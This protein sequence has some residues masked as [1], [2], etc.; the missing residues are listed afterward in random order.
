MVGY[1]GSIP[2][3]T[4]ISITLFSEFKHLHNSGT[5]PNFKRHRKKKTPLSCRACWKQTRHLWSRYAR[6][7]LEHKKW[8]HGIP[9][10][11]PQLPPQERRPC[12]SKSKRSKLLPTVHLMKLT[13]GCIENYNMGF[14]GGL[15]R[16]K[17]TRIL[18]PVSPFTQAGL[19]P[20]MKSLFSVKRHGIWVAP[21][22]NNLRLLILLKSYMGY[23]DDTTFYKV[24][25]IPSVWPGFS[26]NNMHAVFTMVKGSLPAMNS[27]THHSHF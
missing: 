24:L 21:W 9:R 7:C 12:Y 3:D 4:S 22:N 26:N 11:P 27:V 13:I 5:S 6:G 23:I 2:L 8:Y 16:S 10:A 15:M 20:L 19:V 14:Y 17:T 25:H 1:S 18:P